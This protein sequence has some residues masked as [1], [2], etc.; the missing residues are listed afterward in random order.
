MDIVREGS[1]SPGHRNDLGTL[2]KVL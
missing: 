1:G 2:V